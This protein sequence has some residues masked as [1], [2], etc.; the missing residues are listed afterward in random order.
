MALKPRPL[1]CWPGRLGDL[2]GR[3]GGD[4]RPCIALSSRPDWCAIGTRWLAGSLEGARRVL[5]CGLRA[6]RHQQRG[7]CIGP[8]RA[9]STVIV[10]PPRNTSR[11]RH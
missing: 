8:L 10:L 2:T 4:L 6:N 1:G 7:H 9:A 5:L 3:V 11:V